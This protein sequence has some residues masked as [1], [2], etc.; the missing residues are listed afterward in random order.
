MA[1]DS[2]HG[3]SASSARAR[4]EPG[5]RRSR[6]RRAIASCSPTRMRGATA[7]AHARSIAKSMA[8]EVE[9]GRLTRE[10]PTRLIVAHR[11]PVG[12][13]LGD[14]LSRLSRLRPRHR[15]GRRGPRR[16]SERSSRRSR[17]SSRR[18]RVLATNTSSLS[19]AAIASA[20]EAPGARGRH[21]LLQSGAGD[22]AR[23]GRAVARRR[24]DVATAR[25]TRSMRRWEKTPVLA[26]DT[27]GFI[28]NRDRAAVL[29]RVASHARGRRRRRRDDRLGDEGA[30]RLPHGTVRAD[31]LHR[32]RRELRRHA[33]GVRGDVLRSALQ[34]V[35]HAAAARR[36]RAFSAGSRGRG[37][38]DY[39]AGA[40]A[41]EPSK[42]R[43]ARRTRSSSACSRC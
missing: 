13:P 31:G 5:S 2:E 27:P 6:R 15:G 25:R 18:T 35:A 3:R 16:R 21:S 12:E 1:L 30:R 11:F 34:A 14:D 26:S 28:V 17:Q 7:N 39:R 10:P 40:V 19:V 9:K 4:W 22:A 23:R 32:Q 37:Y 41:P 42:D 33:V 43:S 24:S 38:Y 8:R 29:R 36:S 20:C